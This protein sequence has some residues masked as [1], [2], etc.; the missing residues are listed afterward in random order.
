MISEAVNGARN[1]QRMQGADFEDARGESFGDGVI[2]VG[3]EKSAERDY[4][5]HGEA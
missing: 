2:A 5:A 3:E 1:F 4:F